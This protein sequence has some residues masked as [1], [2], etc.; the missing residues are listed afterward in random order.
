MSQEWSAELY[1]GAHRFVSHYGES[2]IAW[3]APRPNERILDLGCGT[4]DLTAR[5]AR[6]GAD[7]VGVDASEAML[8]QA[9]AKFPSLT[10]V[11]G[12]AIAL[13]DLGAPFDAVFSNAVLH[14][15]PDL[16]PVAKELARV[17][18]PGGRFVAEFG[19]EGCKELIYGTLRSVIREYGFVPCTVHFFRP[20]SS[21]AEAF[22]RS[23][24][25]VIR[26]E[27]FPRDT[28]LEGSNGMLNILR[29]FSLGIL[30]DVPSMWREKILI[31]TIE[32]LRPL[33]F[34][35]GVWHAD[36]TRQ[37]LLCTRL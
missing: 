2:L 13:P 12:D 19:G 3:L 24:F 27:W 4:G 15:I 5:L 30:S 34:R 23:G 22:E 29:M 11:H 6:S 36:Y 17:L 26:A 10:F 31:E 1:D 7:V 16:R 9:R 37:R 8:V 21:L 35:E 14:W 25:R 18:R 28:P 32:R 20:L 33:L